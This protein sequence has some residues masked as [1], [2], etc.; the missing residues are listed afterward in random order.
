[1][2]WTNGGDDGD[3]WLCILRIVRIVNAMCE[4][5]EPKKKSHNK[6]QYST[7]ITYVCTNDVVCSNDDDDTGL[8]W[9]QT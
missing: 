8:Q 2:Q 5:R 9:Q 7:F 1:M 6:R 4:L 3:G